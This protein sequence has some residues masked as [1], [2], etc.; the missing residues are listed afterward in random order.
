MPEPQ[1]GLFPWDSL[2]AQTK[3]T[4]EIFPSNIHE[5]STLLSD[6]T[7]IFGN[8]MMMMMMTMLMMMMVIAMMM[9]MM[10]MMMMVT[11]IRLAGNSDSDDES[12]SDS[13]ND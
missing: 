9:M 2:L 4:F 6:G 11:V 1:G 10:M 12:Y 5:R 3:L 13:Y 7:E 8:L